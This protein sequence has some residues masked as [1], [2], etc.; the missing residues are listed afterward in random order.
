MNN[1]NSRPESKG[2]KTIIV[3]IPIILA[4]AAT[5]SVAVML[6]G[7]M[8]TPPPEPMVTEPE[9]STSADL[10][11]VVEPETEGEKFSDSLSFSVGADGRATVVGMGSCTDRIVRI[12]AVT[13][14]GA[15]VT[16]IG[17]SA[18]SN[19][20]GVDEIVMPGSIATIGDYAFRGSSI[21]TVSIG[22]GVISI[23]K[24]AFADCRRLAAINVDG[25]NPMYASRSGVLFDRE[26][27]TLLCYPAG[28]PDASYTIPKSVT[29]IGHMAFYSCPALKKLKYDGNAKQW[30]N[31]LIGSG[32]ALLDS[33]TVEV[34]TSDK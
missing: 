25:A 20:L 29:E 24:G 34:D 22:G 13:A 26:M 28:R 18:F 1:Q 21:T 5:V 2:K 10:P 3:L 30:K 9:A 14:D 16:A 11:V 15:P 23:G 17:D 6:G 32:N 8:N 12:P 7:S 19:A 33:L 31:V 4:I 27:T